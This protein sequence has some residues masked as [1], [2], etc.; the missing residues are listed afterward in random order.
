MP[1]GCWPIWP[2]RGARQSVEPLCSA[3]QAAD[4]GTSVERINLERD[5]VRRSRR[6]AAR[7][8]AGYTVKR[9]YFN[10]EFSAGI[11]NIAFDALEGF[12]SPM[13]L[14]TVKLKDFPWNG[15]LQLGV[16]ARAGGGLE[17]DRR[18]HRRLR[19]ADVVR[20]RRSGRDTVALRGGLDAQPHLR[21]GVRRTRQ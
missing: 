2:A 5:L 18:L 6:A 20:R 3:L 21:G 10:A 17:S 11:E 15:W 13:F 12:N 1:I 4:Y 7:V 16:D 14:R 19:P 8:V 9:E